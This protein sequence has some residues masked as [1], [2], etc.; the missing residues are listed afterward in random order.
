MVASAPTRPPR[1]STAWARKR[2]GLGTVRMD[3][4]HATVYGFLIGQAFRDHRGH[5]PITLEKRPVSTAHSS[6]PRASA[7]SCDWTLPGQPSGTWCEQWN[8]R[9]VAPRGIPV[10]RSASRWTQ[11]AS[12]PAQPPPGRW[13]TH[14]RSLQ[15]RTP[16]SSNQVEAWTQNSLHCIR[17]HAFIAAIN[18][19]LDRD[20]PNA[21]TEQERAQSPEDESRSCVRNRSVRKIHDADGTS[22][23]EFLE[24]PIS[25]YT[26][27]CTRSLTCH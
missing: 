16:R 22:D 13:H 14:S 6:A 1:T 15:N 9:S 10:D 5:K 27:F 12:L 21:R 3:H 18:F 2:P 11:S 4:S 24:H 7:S 20:V 26:S 17:M 8:S 23:I 19:H 25:G